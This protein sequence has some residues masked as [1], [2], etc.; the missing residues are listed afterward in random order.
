MAFGNNLS[1]AC[2]GKVTGK[3][4]ENSFVTSRSKIQQNLHFTPKESDI[5]KIHQSGDL[6]NLDGLDDSSLKLLPSLLTLRDALYSAAFRDYLSAAVTGSGPLLGQKTDMIIN[7]YTPG[8]HLLCH[9][10]VI[11]SRRVSY[12]LYLTN[13]DRPWRAE[14]GGAH[15]LHLTRTF[16][17][18]NGGETKVPSPDFSVSIPPAFDQLTF[19]AVQ[20]GESFHGVEE[21]YAQKEGEKEEDDGGRVR[22]AISRWYHIPQEGEDGYE[23]GLEDRLA[24]KGSLMQVQ[25]K[26]DKYDTPQAQHLRPRILLPSLRH[27]FS[28]VLLVS[29]LLHHLTRIRVPSRQPSSAEIEV[30]TDWKV[31][32]PPHRLRF[33]FQ[34]PSLSTQDLTAEILFAHTLLPHCGNSLL[35]GRQ[36]KPIG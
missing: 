25:G 12:I 21:V 6:A 4:V 11:Q 36:R 5:Y 2:W 30:S 13:P 29:L 20:P 26:G 23:E 28:E 9:D 8:C 33:L 10:D 7:V 18:D 35:A 27:T 31:T 14:W 24:E 16:I 19:F 3:M 32:H 17:G 15:R 1:S 34:R 22:M